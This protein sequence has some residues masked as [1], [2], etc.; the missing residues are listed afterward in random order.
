MEFIPKR[1]PWFG[2][3]W[4]RLTGLTKRSLKKVLGRACVTMESLEAT[5]TAIKAILNDRLLTYVSSYPQDLQLLTPA[6]LLHGRRLGST[7]S[8]L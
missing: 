4:E 8:R 2:E 3:F 1:A 5:V 6:H 7:W